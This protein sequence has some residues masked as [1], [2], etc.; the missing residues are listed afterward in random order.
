MWTKPPKAPAPMTSLNPSKCRRVR[1]RCRVERELFARSKLGSPGREGCGEQ[2]W[3]RGDALCQNRFRET[4]LGGRLGVG[5]WAED[6]CIKKQLRKRGARSESPNDSPLEGPRNRCAW[7]FSSG[8]GCLPP[9]SALVD[10][11]VVD[12]TA[13]RQRAIGG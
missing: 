5:G 3:Q 7:C 9:G 4:S 8:S 1:Q 11:S 10:T 6:V 2:R 12:W 13:M